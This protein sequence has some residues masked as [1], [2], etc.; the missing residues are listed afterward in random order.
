MLYYRIIGISKGIDSTKNNRSKE[1]MICHY[2]IYN[3]GFKFQDSVCNGCHDLTIL[4]LNVRDINTVKNIE[5]FKVLC[6][7]VMDISKKY[8]LNF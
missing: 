3:H 5:M 1:C 2:W 4:S 8:C 7:K 6:L